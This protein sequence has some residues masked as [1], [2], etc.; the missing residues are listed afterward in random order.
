MKTFFLVT[1]WLAL[2][3]IFLIFLFLVFIEVDAY[4][5]KWLVISSGGFLFTL[6]FGLYGLRKEKHEKSVQVPGDTRK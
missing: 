5:F 1:S 4:Q 6:T 3:G 2:F